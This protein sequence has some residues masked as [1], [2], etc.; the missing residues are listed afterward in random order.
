VFATLGYI[1][2]IAWWARPLIRNETVGL[3]ELF[4]LRPQR[5]AAAG[6]RAAPR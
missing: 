5:S 3:L 4:A 6:E 2:S 1:L